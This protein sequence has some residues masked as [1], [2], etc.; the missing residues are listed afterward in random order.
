MS[1]LASRTFWVAT[2]ERAVKT[3][4]QAAIL[5]LGADQVNALTADW[6]LVTGF[7]AGGFALSVLTSLASL[8][9]TGDGPS[10][11]HAERIY[12]ARHGDSS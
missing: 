6:E 11:T 12:D 10:A 5:T 1:T 8:K 9:A 4:A 2:G 3:A 7:A